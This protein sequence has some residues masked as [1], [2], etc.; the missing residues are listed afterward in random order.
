MLSPDWF[1]C[2]D[3][4]WSVMVT[5]AHARS[6]FHLRPGDLVLTGF[7]WQEGRTKP[8][9]QIITP[10]QDHAGYIRTWACV[11]EVKRADAERCV[12]PGGVACVVIKL[13]KQI[14]EIFL[15]GHTVVWV[16]SE[17]S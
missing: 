16:N 2:L 14:C 9:V 10:V 1:V 12:L 15:A 13:N 4:F 17:K 7:Q 3:H 6:S 8:D 11:V 5:R